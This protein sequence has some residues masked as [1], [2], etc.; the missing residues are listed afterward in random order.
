VGF[1]LESFRLAPD[2]P[3]RHRIIGND[4]QYLYGPKGFI[5]I[6]SGLQ[7]DVGRWLVENSSI[8]EGS[9]PGTV[10]LWTMLTDLAFETEELATTGENTE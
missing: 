10:N 3:R 9:P 7:P 6:K 4:G 8:L 1:Y 5:A 2:G